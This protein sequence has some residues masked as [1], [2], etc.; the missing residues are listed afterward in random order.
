MYGRFV[1]PFAVAV[2]LLVAAGAGPIGSRTC[3]A[4][5]PDS[6][7]GD[8]AR[9]VTVNGFV[10]GSY[11]Y[12]F[13]RPWTRQ[14]ADRVFD[15]D[16]D[17]FKLDVF[18]LVVQH[19]ATN[20]R[21]GGFRVDVTAGGSVPRVSAASGLF[22]DA[23]TGEAQDVD[24]HQA[25]VRYV[26]PLGSG[27]QLDFGKFVT[28]CGTEVIEGYDGWNDDATR[29][30]LFGWAIPFTHTGLRAAYTLDPHVSVTGMVVNGWD[31]ATDANHRKT[32][33]AQIALTGPY[34]SSCAVTA[35]SGPEQGA[36]DGHPRQ[37]LDV[38]IALKPTACASLGLNAD[39]GNE[40]HLFAPGGPV[41]YPYRRFSHWDGLAGYAR[42]QATRRFALAGR[43]ES[44]HD[45]Q[46]ARTGIAQVI[47]EV[48]LT[49]ELRLDAHVVVRLDL[50]V[51]ASDVRS[52]A[53]RT[54]STDS[55]TTVLLNVLA[56]F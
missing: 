14:N 55:Q 53:A 47:R 50:R 7:A 2:L 48:T 1:R 12:N 18:E 25:Y 56:S 10:S 36:D 24:V 52:F 22:R 13:A 51:D 29:S 37:L 49:P 3:S 38:V 9:H 54:A 32:I 11:S 5:E 26:A 40:D 46:G 8:W 35:L 42:W 15:F 20:P 21:E 43:A 31:N 27:L 33:G 17:T 23:I 45:R 4:G 34:G 41:P 44:F 19:A 30:L 16:D 39:V 6:S 28:P